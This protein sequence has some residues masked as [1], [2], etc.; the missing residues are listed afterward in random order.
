MLGGSADSAKR[1][2]FIF[3]LQFI[4]MLRCGGQSITVSGRVGDWRSG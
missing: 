1:E 4:C 3:A 2:G